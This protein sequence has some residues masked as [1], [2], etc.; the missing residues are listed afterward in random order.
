[1]KET[2]IKKAKINPAKISVL[3]N[4]VKHDFLEESQALSD[5]YRNR[6]KAGINQNAFVVGFAGR[7]IERKGWADFLKAAKIIVTT[8]SETGI[9]FIIA[10]I[11]PDERALKKQIIE[12]GLSSHVQYLGFIE[13]M[14][15]FYSIVDC[16]VMPSKWEGLPLVQLESMAKGVPL[17][18]YNGPGMNEVPTNN[19]D[20][21]TVESGNIKELSE[22]IILLKKNRQIGKRIKKAAQNTVLEMNP[23]NYY[24]NLEFLYHSIL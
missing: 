5:K 4:C 24:A 16:C 11:G 12:L 18:T 21:L 7:I 3:F 13:E 9:L 6:Q 20:S 1:M 10:G 23:V 14:K 17:I 8:K 19:L 2:L 15:Q 22:K